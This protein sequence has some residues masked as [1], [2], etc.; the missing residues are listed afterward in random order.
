MKRGVLL[1][2]NDILLKLIFI[3]D[4]IISATGLL[5]YVQEIIVKLSTYETYIDDIQYYL[6]GAYFFLGKPLIIFVVGVSATVFAIK[7]IGAI[8]MIISQFIP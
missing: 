7:L 8:V 4:D 5:D 1:M 3:F 2:V 6:S